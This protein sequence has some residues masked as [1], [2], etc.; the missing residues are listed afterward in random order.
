MEAQERTASSSLALVP[1]NLAAGG[2]A[3]YS[4]RERLFDFGH[5][6]A[7]SKQGPTIVRIKQSWNEEE[8]HLDDGEGSAFGLGAIV[9]AT[10]VVL[11][12]YLRDHRE[13]MVRDK[14]VLEL[15]CGTG[16]AGIVCACSGLGAREVVLSDG[17]STLLQLTKENVE[18]NGVSSVTRTAALP[19]GESREETAKRL[20]TTAPFDLV[21]ASD[22]VALPYASQVDALLATISSVSG[23]E[24]RII[25]AQKCRADF[26]AGAVERRFFRRASRLFQV[27]EVARE[28]LHADFRGDNRLQLFEMRLLPLRIAGGA[29]SAAVGV[30]EEEEEDGGDA[31]AAAATGKE[32]EES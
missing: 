29:S 25:L 23:P 15:G 12:F 22:C 26:G 20:G 32:A 8:G 28:R 4:V 6:S 10:E 19:W 5:L 31:A 24:T 27:S 11:S 9:Y 14:R 7:C 16:L 13:S 17:D 21:L 18:L 1:F 3:H 2:G 30:Q